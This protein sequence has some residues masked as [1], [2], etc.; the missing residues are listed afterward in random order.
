MRVYQCLLGGADAL[1]P[2]CRH[3]HDL[4]AKRIGG[5]RVR[6]LGSAEKR[7]GGALSRPGAGVSRGLVQASAAGVLA[8]RSILGDGRPAV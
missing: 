2:R 4:D 5:H 7:Q 3:D 1:A 8:A 6:E